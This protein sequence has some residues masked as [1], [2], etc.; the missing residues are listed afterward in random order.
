MTIKPIGR[1]CATAS[2]TLVA[3]TAI[4]TMALSSASQAIT[5]DFDTFS[6]GTIMTGQTISGATFSVANQGTTGGNPR[7]LMIFDAD[8]GGGPAS[9][10]SGGDTDLYFPGEGSV[11]IISEDN[12]SNDP[13]DSAAGGDIFVDFNPNVFNVVSVVLDVEDV[14]STSNYVSA[15]LDGN[16]LQTII[17]STPNNGLVTA[18]FGAIELDQL[19]IHFAGSGAIQE[20]SFTAVPLPGAFALLLSGLGLMGVL[21]RRA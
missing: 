12:D 19:Q 13:D 10:C 15:F 20:I 21:R 4:L 11:L 18:N 8:C 14:S 17:V 7:E 16:L 9:N 6:E 3:S 5:I 1:L 2:S